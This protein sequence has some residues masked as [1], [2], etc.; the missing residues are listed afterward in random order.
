VDARPVGTLW[1][2]LLIQ[3]KRKPDCGPS[4]N[5][6]GAA[7]SGSASRSAQPHLQ[8][9]LPGGQQALDLARTVGAGPSALYLRHPIERVLIE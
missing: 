6:A 2:H 5:S 9:A 4:S 3:F 1:T 7:F 8:Q